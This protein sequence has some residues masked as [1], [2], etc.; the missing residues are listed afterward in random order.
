VSIIPVSRPVGRRDPVRSATAPAVQTNAIRYVLGNATALLIGLVSAYIALSRGTDVS[1]RIHDFMEYFSASHLVVQ[2][3]GGDLYNLPLLGNVQSS[4]AY[5]LWPGRSVLPFLYPPYVAVALAPLAALPYTLAFLLWLALNCILFFTVTYALER[6]AGLTGR[7]AL[8]LRLGSVCSL[9]VFMALGLGQISVLLLALFTLVFFA[10]RAGRDGTAGVALA[11][12]LVKPAYVVP[13]LVVLLVK[14]RWRALA[15]FGASTVLLALVALPFCGVS[16]NF[17][18]LRTLITVSSWQGHSGGVVVRD[19]LV[20]PATYAA[21]WNHSFAGFVQLLLH[22]AAALAASIGFTLIALL[23]LARITHTHA[24]VD[25]P[26]GMAAV[27]ALLISPHTLAYDLTILLLPVG[28]ALRY[29]Q[30]TSAGLNALL[31][32]TYVLIFI[33]YRLAFVVPLQ[34]SVL[35]MLALAVWLCLVNSSQF[36]AI[37]AENRRPATENQ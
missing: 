2:G 5:P 26:L 34:L 8:L 7:R 9:P 19:V 12:A 17:T 37:S 28:V 21:Q 31:I 4:L 3:H 23:L 20:A 29:R 24:E 14:H 30:G 27:L 15:A 13:F 36:S 1:I 33:G 22:S 10:V 32:A 18:Y 11:V 16:I 25:I 35:V 6:Y